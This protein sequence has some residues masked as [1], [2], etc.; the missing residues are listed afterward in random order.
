MRLYKAGEEIDPADELMQGDALI[1]ANFNLDPENLN[2]EKW[3][4]LF[5]EA[6]WIE[7]ERLKNLGML[8]CQMWN[9][10]DIS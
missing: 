2:E 5:C 7:Q 9:G 6:V 3:A 4:K 8:I 10:C 1:R